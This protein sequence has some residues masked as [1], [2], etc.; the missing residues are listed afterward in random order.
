M[1]LNKLT[2]APSSPPPARATR[3]TPAKAPKPEVGP[4]AQGAEFGA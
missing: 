1:S 4:R 3:A 2:K